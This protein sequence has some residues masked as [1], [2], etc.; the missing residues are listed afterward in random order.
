MR[1][2]NPKLSPGANVSPSLRDSTPPPS[3]GGRAPFAS[4][5]PYDRAM[6]LGRRAYFIGKWRIIPRLRTDFDETPFHP[7]IASPRFAEFR[8]KRFYASL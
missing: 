5:R 2:V 3:A 4:S 6:G 8:V 7:R 1:T